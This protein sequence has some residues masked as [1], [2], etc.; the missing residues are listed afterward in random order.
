V[1]PRSPC[2]A[3]LV[4]LDLHHSFYDGLYTGSV[5]DACVRPLKQNL[6]LLVSVLVD[7]APG[8]EGTRSRRLLL[9]TALA[10]V[11][12]APPPCVAP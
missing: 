6:S 5:T 7:G 10:T 12:G 1:S 3:C 11:A 4:F 8:D 9:P 2:T